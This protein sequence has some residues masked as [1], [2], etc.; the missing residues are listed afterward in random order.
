MSKEIEIKIDENKVDADLNNID[1]T[2][3]M[4][5][6]NIPV[7][8]IRRKKLEKLDKAHRDMLSSG[9]RS[10]IIN[11]K[12]RD[13]VIKTLKDIYENPVNRMFAATLNVVT[14]GGDCI[15]SNTVVFAK[16]E[17]DEERNDCIVIKNAN[18]CIFVSKS[19]MN[20]YIFTSEPHE[21]HLIFTY[22]I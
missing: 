10:D 11:F 2:K 7:D 22:T 16:I 8:D 4:L 3:G 12:K 14:K 21:G 20:K 13:S 5:I 6:L 9:N 17:D 18:T 1:G 19:I 15:A